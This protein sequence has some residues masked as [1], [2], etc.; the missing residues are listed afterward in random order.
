MLSVVRPTTMSLCDDRPRAQCADLHG[1]C[2]Q[3]EHPAYCQS[4]FLAYD[5]PYIALSVRW[6]RT[7]RRLIP[8]QPAAILCQGYGW[9]GP[10]VSHDIG[11]GPAF[12]IRAWL[13][14]S[15]TVSI[16]ISAPTSI[17]PPPASSFLLVS[18]SLPACQSAGIS[19][20]R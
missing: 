7:P 6:G 12:T 3:M 9:P 1:D 13:F 8:R 15:V 5:V 11:W 20:C 17:L 10:T 2:R 18:V 14:I 19:E 16:S 4:P